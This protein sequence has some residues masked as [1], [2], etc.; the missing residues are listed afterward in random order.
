HGLWSDKPPSSTNKFGTRVPV[1]LQIH[2]VQ[3]RHHPAL[4]VANARHVEREAVV[5]DAKFFAPAKIGSD[6]CAMD[7]VLARQTR[8]IRAGPTN[9][10]TIDRCHTFSL[11][12]KCPGSE[13]GSGAAA[14]DDQVKFFR[15][16]GLS[17]VGR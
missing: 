8:D 12:S 14:Q 2:L 1:V 16:P 9:I 5:I 11:G 7:N 4:A 13:S 15:R 17:S 6:L 10:F 3:S